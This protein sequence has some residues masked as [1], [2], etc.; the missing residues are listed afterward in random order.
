MVASQKPHSEEGVTGRIHFLF[1]S[2][3]SVT[4]QSSGSRAEGSWQE[5]HQGPSFQGCC[6]GPQ[7]GRS[8]LL[9][10]FSSRTK[11]IYLSVCLKQL[12]KERFPSPTCLCC[13][14]PIFSF[15]TDIRQDDWNTEP[16]LTLLLNEYS[17]PLN[18]TG[19]SA[20]NAPCSWKPAYK[21]WL[22]QNLTAV[23]P[24]C[25]Q[26]SGSRNLPHRHPLPHITL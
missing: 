12:C 22:P 2:C 4:R 21:F 1:L 26:L 8:P 13:H 14:R 24:W 18:N 19:V 6:L 3:P 9:F 20:T 25:P 17:W 10:G 5:S 16:Y 23:I 11:H 15:S 7:L